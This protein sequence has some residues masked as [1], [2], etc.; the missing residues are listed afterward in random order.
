MLENLINEEEN[1]E[2]NTNADLNEKYKFQWDNVTLNSYTSD[3]EI[4]ENIR[5]KFKIIAE[6]IGTPK[7]S[8]RQNK[9]L[10][11]PFIFSK[12]ETVYLYDKYLC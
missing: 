11:K 7:T 5:K 3:Y 1:N 10:T 12:F 4:V 9:I 2:G 8:R 6:G